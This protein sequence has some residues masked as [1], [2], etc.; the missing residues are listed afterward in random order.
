VSAVSELWVT[1]TTP[2]GTFLVT[3]QLTSISS[4]TDVNGT[5]FFAAAG[6][7]TGVELW[8]SDGT[9]AGTVLVEDIAFGVESIFPRHL[10]AVGDTLFFSVTSFDGTQI[11][12]SD[13]TARGTVPVTTTPSQLVRD[14]YEING[15]Y[16][17]VRS[18]SG[19]V[20]VWT[21]D[22]T[23]AGT[24]QVADV[25]GR[26]VA[27]S[28]RTDNGLIF[29]LIRGPIVN[30]STIA[31]AIWVSDGTINGTNEV[32]V[33]T[34]DTTV[35]GLTTSGDKLYYAVETGGS[36]L[37]NYSIWESDGT[38]GNTRIVTDLSQGEEEILLNSRQFALAKIGDSLV[39]PAIDVQYGNELRKV[40]AESTLV[41]DIDGDGKVGFSDFLRISSNFGKDH[42]VIYAD[43]D[44]DLNGKI[45]L[46]D[47]ILLVRHFGMNSGQ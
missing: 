21:S 1:D 6:E 12:T 37:S 38:P 46:D 22:G 9:E 42:D 7:N 4:I 2:E 27:D 40:N 15:R 20:E 17:Q 34:N 31:S 19:R 29:M 23:E 13:G 33:F 24:M 44:L 3:D 8:R 36:G 45:D 25:E 41:G 18:P 43:G 10:Q 16:V 47:F 32:Q 26:L 39:F 11:W 28:V 35:I 30:Q 5:A 14:T